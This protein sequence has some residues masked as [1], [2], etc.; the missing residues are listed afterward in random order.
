MSSNFLKGR[1]ITPGAKGVIEGESMEVAF[2]VDLP[3][4]II[5][6]NTVTVTAREPHNKSVTF[7][8]GDVQIQGVD[9]TWWDLEWARHSEPEKHRWDLVEIINK[10]GAQA[11]TDWECGP[12]P[13]KEYKGFFEKVFLACKSYDLIR[14]TEFYNALIDLTLLM[15]GENDDLDK[16]AQEH[17]DV[18]AFTVYQLLTC[19]KFTKSGIDWSNLNQDEWLDKMESFKK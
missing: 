10:H 4:M 9:E 18:T 13:Y 14:D 7:Q 16:I 19:R 6:H 17:I 3:I 12:Y 5:A 15:Y 11:Y 8:T 1:I 2:P